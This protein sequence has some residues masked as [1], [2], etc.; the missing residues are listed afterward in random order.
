MPSE[1]SASQPLVM[2]A[3][4]LFSIFGI[5]VFLAIL[6]ELMA[7]FLAT[8]DS[9]FNTAIQVIGYG[10]PL[11]AGAQAVSKTVGSALTRYG[12]KSNE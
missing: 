10:G 3:I 8:D 11:T 12:N 6:G 2:S 9:L 5:V 4:F 7:R 1:I